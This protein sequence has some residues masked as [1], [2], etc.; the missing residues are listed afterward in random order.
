[1]ADPV[2]KRGSK[3]DAV[4]RLQDLLRN[5]GDYDPGAVD[6]IFGSRTETAVKEFQ[7]NNGLAADGVVGP[8]SW[9]VLNTW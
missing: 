1:M 2:L 6:G 8:A 7:T 3:G 4:R 5:P 9:A